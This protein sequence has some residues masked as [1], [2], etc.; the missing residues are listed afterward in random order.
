MRKRG[1]LDV[2]C[3]ICPGFRIAAVNGNKGY[4]SFIVPSRNGIGI[5]NMRAY[6]VIVIGHHIGIGAKIKSFDQR[7]RIKVR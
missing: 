1:L 2:W 7:P 5:I 3:V 4:C 6:R